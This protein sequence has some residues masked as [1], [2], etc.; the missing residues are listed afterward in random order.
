MIGP[1]T[2]LASPRELPD[3]N[4][5]ISSSPDELI[6]EW[7]APPP[8]IS[9]GPEGRSE[10]E[11]PGF[12]NTNE[13]GA[14]RVPV[15]SVL[16][17]IPPGAEPAIEVQ[18]SS[19]KRVDLNSPLALGE[20][21]E[22]V[23]LNPAGEVIGGGF[24]TP[25]QAIE[26][27]FEPV[28][29]ELVGV[30]RGAQLARLSFYPALPSGERLRLTSYLKV[31]VNFAAQLKSTISTTSD[32][33]TAALKS[34]VINPEHLQVASPGE[35]AD[36][37]GPMLALG[38]T[39]T[40]AIEVSEPG[41]TEISYADL[42]GIG[43][44]VTGTN[45]ENLHL[46]R[47]G[48]SVAY[49]WLGDDDD[50]FE[51]LESIRFF[52]DPRFSRWTTSDTYFLSVESTPGLHMQERLADGGI[53]AG[54]PRVESLFE[55]NNIYTPQCYCAPIPPGR[56]GDRW[57]WDRL[58]RPAPATG[59]YEFLLSG[60]DKSQDANLKIWLIGFT[61]LTVK[62]DHKVQVAVNGSNQGT[63]NWD[64][65]SIVGKDF[66]IPGSV[67]KEG[68]NELK[69]TLL[70]TGAEI[71][72]IWLD[73]FSIRH[74]RT[75]SLA[76]DKL[77]LFSG[78]NSRK[79]YTFSV[80]SGT[81]F[82]AYDVTDPDQPELL[83]GIPSSTTSITISD[84]QPFSNPNHEYWFGSTA[85]I[86]T[87]DNLRMVSPARLGQGFK[88]ADYLIISPAEFIPSL[89][90]LISLRQS[91]GLVV[92]VEDVQAI[93]D[94]Y[95][96]GRPLPSAI[97]SFLEEAYF[98]WDRVPLYVLLAADG[99]HDP[100]GYVSTPSATLIPPFLAEVDPWAGE[101]ATDNRYV[102]VDGEDNLPDMLIGRLPADSIAE[103]ETM[104]S[105]IVVNEDVPPLT[106]WQRKALFVADDNDP[107]SGD[108]P[109]LSDILISQF[110]NQPFGPQRLYYDPDQT[111]KEN[112][113]SDLQQAWDAGSG[114]IMFT[115]HSSIYFWAQEELLHLHTVPNLQN[116]QKLP[117][118]L[119]MTCFTG[120]FQFPDDPIHSAT[121]TL[122]EEMLRH[123][124]GGAVAVWGSTGLGVSTGHHWLAEGFMK[125]VYQDGISEIGIAT[126]AG[127]LNL[128][129]V[130]TSLDLIDTFNL[131][132]DPATKLARSYQIYLPQTQN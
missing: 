29:L 9:E 55:E 33:L 25:T 66:T 27:P 34:A 42:A 88:G 26:P 121:A 78:E 67:L 13:P 122:D 120:S 116:G 61:E 6:V 14:P 93:Y 127:R 100:R 99:T 50:A 101:T 53:T 21:P 124:G 91:N 37:P 22:G 20:Q 68:T 72:G 71:D 64:G 97:Y 62:P 77:L 79:E 7:S 102:T 112:F 19:A 51:P 12:S 81:S 123:P 56:D 38:N 44:P 111:T 3:S 113:R 30:M 54:V 10:I 109:S 36:L 82:S 49:Q 75:L 63:I 110:P 4:P 95:G 47:S 83:T 131:L 90:P 11:I 115:G 45:P 35:S 104:V 18:D 32:P 118:V 73:A 86:L 23:K 94:A 84:P 128:L 65:K 5:L 43:F 39:A 15:S 69:L 57:V 119:E 130:G 126:L 70:D 28:K 92:A 96:D 87:A 125:T 107:R 129:S 108:F 106:P 17:A 24:A 46:A 48:N 40:A 60:V 52:A 98:T 89:A 8:V 76:A 74:A 41:I 132:G 16:V 31:K 80:P 103:F 114:L 1:Q 117:V 59:T 2:S 58:Q 105:K 85:K